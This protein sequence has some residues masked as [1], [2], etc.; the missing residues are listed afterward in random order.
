MNST[1]LI[2]LVAIASAV[3]F[4]PVH[5]AS[6]ERLRGTVSLDGSSTVFPISEAVAEEFGSVQPRVRVT[7]GVSGTG[8]GFKKFLA[9]E[10]DI[11][12][13]SRPI[14]AKELNMAREKGIEFLELP[15][16]YDGLSIVVNKSNNWVNH[17][18]IA[19]LN[20][21]WQAGSTVKTWKDVRA[22]W[23]NITIKLYGPGTD[24]GTFDY[25]TETVNGKLGASRPDYTSSEDDNALVQGVSGDTG[26]LGYFGFAYY[27][28]N[29][30]RLKLVPIDGGN[31][32]ILPS[33]KSINDGS[34]AP[35]SRPVFIYVRNKALEIGRAHV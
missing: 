25:F 31:G 5:S 10:T 8:G 34:Y 16:A 7:V 30:S 35:L 28:A 4:T 14:K 24:S 11:N 3:S 27:E 17:L 9:G 19:E 32:P 6:A 21:I 33:A 20:K 13:A 23:P 18:S 1:K 29:K 26:S 15:I 22:S 12:N 2:K